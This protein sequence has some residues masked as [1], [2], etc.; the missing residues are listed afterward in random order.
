MDNEKKKIVARL[1][2]IEG[3]VRG[4]QRLIENGAPCIDVLTQVSAV[5]S[6]MKKTGAAI[7]NAHMETCMKESTGNR[8]KERS[9][10]QTALSRFIDLS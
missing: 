9:D 10:F 2:R 6:A 3:Q 5:T 7:I 1:K 8:A 4:L